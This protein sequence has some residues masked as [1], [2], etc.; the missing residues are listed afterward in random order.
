MTKSDA[1]GLDGAIPAATLILLRDRDGLV[2]LMVER[3]PAIAFAGGALVFPGGRIDP[4]DDDPAWRKQASGL[5]ADPAIARGQIA[6][7]R[8]AFEETGLVLARPSRGAGGEA[9]FVSAARARDL[10]D[11]RGR[12]EEDDRMFL[13]MARTEDLV[14]A[15]DAIGLFAHWV[16]PASVSKRFDTLF[17][18]AVAPPDQVPHADGHEAL[19]ALWIRP[20]DALGAADAGRR[21]IIFPTRRNLERLAVFSSAADVLADAAGRTVRPILPAV[22]ARTDGSWLTIPDDQ[23]YPVTAEKLNRD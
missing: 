5:S 23:G 22:E 3:H 19:E 8:E 1:T 2:V 6:A 16:A 13:E 20:C 11:W 18:A 21:K 14:I 9:G 15:A 17:F 7:A 4:G 12:V 10:S